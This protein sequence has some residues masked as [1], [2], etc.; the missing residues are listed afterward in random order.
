MKYLALIILIASS[1]NP[2]AKLQRKQDQA[3]NVVLASKQHL[4]KV[5]EV[6]AEQNPCVV[7]TA[8]EFIQ[9]DTITQIETVI[10]YLPG[11]TI[12]KTLPAK[13]ITNTRIR[14]IRDTIKIFSTDM[15]QIRILQKQKSALYDSLNVANSR[16]QD[17]QSKVKGKVLF[18][19]WWLLIAA[20]GIGAFVT[21][22]LKVW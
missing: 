20:A 7:D 14:T 16:V 17:L 6:W 3:V 13:I 11:D 18:P 8:I 21:K 1:C 9:G 12:T 22:K 19:W 10:E 15:R 2:A 5:G 4:D